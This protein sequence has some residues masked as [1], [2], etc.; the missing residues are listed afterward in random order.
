MRKSQKEEVYE[1]RKFPISSCLRNVKSIEPRFKYNGR[2]CHAALP[3]KSPPRGILPPV[4]IENVYETLRSACQFNYLDLERNEGFS[5][6]ND[7]QRNSV[8]TGAK[9]RFS[10]E[11]DM[12]DRAK[13]TEQLINELHQLRERVAE[14]QKGWAEAALWESGRTTPAGHRPGATHDLREKLGWEISP[15]KQSGRQGLQHEC[16]CSYR[17][18]SRRRPSPREANFKA[19]CGM[20]VKS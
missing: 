7:C 4:S 6:H 18:I 17:K 2:K 10:E 9:C 11:P 13:T 14:L 15:C 8:Y 20:T 5:W 3:F 1:R 16:Q 12:Q 19:C